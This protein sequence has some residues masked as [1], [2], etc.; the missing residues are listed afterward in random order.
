MCVSW[1]LKFFKPWISIFTADS[2]REEGVLH[3]NVCR[4]LSHL[5]SVNHIWSWCRWLSICTH[6]SYIHIFIFERTVFIFPVDLWA[7]LESRW[8]INE[9]V[10]FTEL[11][12]IQWVSR[13]FKKLKNT[14]DQATARPFSLLKEAGSLMKKSSGSEGHFTES[15]W[16]NNTKSKLLLPV[17][18]YPFRFYW[19]V[20]AF[21]IGQIYYSS[22]TLT[23]IK[24]QK[25][26]LE[27]PC[28]P[29]L[30]VCPFIYCNIPQTVILKGCIRFV[31][32]R[33]RRQP[34]N[35]FILKCCYFLVHF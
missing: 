19:A 27:H 7:E 22:V 11:D 10:S 33:S 18:F 8:W 1:H 13:L 28:H 12:R 34:F 3:S 17:C 26:R 20:W 4:Q 14:N 35:V 31:P 24:A 32:L 25:W 16:A 2:A 15:F 23:Q 30:P 5:S 9:S 21:L 29:H 6:F